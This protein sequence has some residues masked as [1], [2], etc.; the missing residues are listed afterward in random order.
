MGQ[1]NS[2]VQADLKVTCAQSCKEWSDKDYNTVKVDLALIKTLDNLCIDCHDEV[3]TVCPGSKVDSKGKDKGTDK[4]LVTDQENMAP[5]CFKAS[6]L[7]LQSD[8]NEDVSK[9]STAASTTAPLTGNEP[10]VPLLNLSSQPLPV[11]SVQTAGDKQ[12]V[13]SSEHQTQPV[14]AC[15][16]EKDL[17]QLKVAVMGWSDN[18]QGLDC[19][20][21][22]PISYGRPLK[23]K[24]TDPP[25][26][27]LADFLNIKTLLKEKKIILKSGKVLDTDHMVL[28]TPRKL[29]LGQTLNGSKMSSEAGMGPEGPQ[30]LLLDPESLRKV[31]SSN[32][33]ESHA[34]TQMTVALMEWS[35]SQQSL[36]CW[37]AVAISY[38]NGIHSD[39]K[40]ADF[41]NLLNERKIMLKSGTV[42]NTDNMV[43]TT[44][45]NLVLDQAVNGSQTLTQAG[46]TSE[47]PV[48]LL[49]D[50]ESLRKVRS[51][52]QKACQAAVEQ[53]VL[54]PQSEI[55]PKQASAPAPDLVPQPTLA[56]AP[57]PGTPQPEA[58]Q[59]KAS[60][61]TQRSEQK[62]IESKAKAQK[63]QEAQDR[64]DQNLETQL[65][66]QS[67]IQVKS[68][69]K[70]AGFK[71]VNELARKQL[72]TKT[73]PLHVAVQKG[74]A[75]MIRLLLLMGADPQL[76]N[77]K[78]ETPLE[79]AKRI[80]RE[81]TLS[82]AL[83][84]QVVSELSPA[85]K[86]GAR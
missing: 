1:S 60:P 85:Q 46:V 7:D 21:T 47:E 59:K 40:V 74:D 16:S 31:R 73:R 17:L 3:K 49:V 10:K 57:S 26:L 84:L 9:A 33:K 50:T 14:W 18:Q 32:R 69:L 61:R 20:E 19:L 81:R 28:T 4:E 39:L 70:R 62:V 54:E 22:I 67:Q 25:D 64:K 24:L 29:E 6:K 2:S 23:L 5:N 12:I 48:L 56:Q 78:N 55:E 43:L 82:T 42:L 86:Y 44:P 53:K 30:L 35:E 37:E 36:V 63:A 58:A 68:W 71:D 79:Y 52:N 65:P 41:R 77:G 34:E 72:L 13:D 80:S 75:E 83:Y 15:K 51:S 45:R 76:R 38:G 66:I 11:E 27:K 8:Q